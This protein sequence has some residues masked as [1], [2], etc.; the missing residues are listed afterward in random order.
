M[1]P[2]KGSLR[3]T[4]LIPVVPLSPGPER[5]LLELIVEPAGPGA[6]SAPVLHPLKNHGLEA[7]VTLAETA[8]RVVRL[9]SSPRLWTS[10][11]ATLGPPAVFVANPLPGLSNARGAALGI[12][13]GLLMYDGHCPG[14]RLIA[15]GQLLPADSTA[16]LIKV[17]A[18]DG[19]A[20]KLSTALTLGY[21]RQPLPFIVPARTQDGRDTQERCAAT[22]RGLANYNIHVLPVASL[23]EAVAACCILAESV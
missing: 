4:V 2:A 16:G 6:G 9:P 17:E 1:I 19:L 7:A 21:Q 5:Y 12:A 11:R 18:T 14:D 8:L 3:K 10:R 13:L 23:Q 15:T 22:V 20:A